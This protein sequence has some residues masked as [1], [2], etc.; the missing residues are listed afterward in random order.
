[1]ESYDQNIRRL[2]V[3]ERIAQLA[4]DYRSVPRDRRLRRG[5]LD[6]RELLDAGARKAN[7]LVQP[8]HWWP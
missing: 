2:I 3:Q 8:A 1:M 4:R 7:R 5:E 6:P